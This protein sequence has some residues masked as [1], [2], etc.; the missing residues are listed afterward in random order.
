MFLKTE[1]YLLPQECEKCP[2]KFTSNNL[3]CWHV[4]STYKATS[5][6]LLG[7]H[8]KINHKEIITVKVHLFENVCI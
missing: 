8:E 5:N 2:A 3:F 1:N 7:K 4:K 6:E